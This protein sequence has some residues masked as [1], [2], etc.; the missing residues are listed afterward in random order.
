MKCKMDII[1]NN[2]SYESTEKRGSVRVRLIFVRVCKSKG[3][4]VWVSGS[5][6]LLENVHRSKLNYLTKYS[7]SNHTNILL[8]YSGWVMQ[9]LR[10]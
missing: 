4:I 1:N 5:V 10:I 6:S 2:V 7:F 9:H 8:T 3:L